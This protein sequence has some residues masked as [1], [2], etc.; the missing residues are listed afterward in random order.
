MNTYPDFA[1]YLGKG[2][3]GTVVDSFKTVEG[4]FKEIKFNRSLE[5]NYQLISSAIY[6]KENADKISEKF[7]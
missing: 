2:K 4:R 1:L 6:K 5:E 3:K 7:I